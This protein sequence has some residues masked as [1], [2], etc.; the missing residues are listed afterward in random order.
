MAELLDPRRARQRRDPALCFVDVTD[1][2]AF[3]K[4][5]SAGIYIRVSKQPPSTGRLPGA[6]SRALSTINIVIGGSRPAD[7]VQ[8]V[9]PRYDGSTSVGQA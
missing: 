3:E 7:A 9:V 5:A 1:R 2:A 6:V 4:R 8:V